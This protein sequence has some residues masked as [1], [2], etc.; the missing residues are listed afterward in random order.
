MLCGNDLSPEHELKIKQMKVSKA[1]IIL[2]IKEKECF[3][4]WRERQE[5]EANSSN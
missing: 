3:A 2:V 5:A 1:G 4:R